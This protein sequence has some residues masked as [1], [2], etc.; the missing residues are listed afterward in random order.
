MAEVQHDHHKRKS[1]E[2]HAVPQRNGKKW[3]ETNSH[4]RQDHG[5]YG[6][7]LSALDGN[8]QSTPGEIPLHLETTDPSTLYSNVHLGDEQV[9]AGEHRNSN[10]A[11]D[12]QELADVG[13]Y[14]P[15]PQTYGPYSAGV[16]KPC[17]DIEPGPSPPPYVVTTSPDG[18]IEYYCMAKECFIDTPPFPTLAEFKQHELRHVPATIMQPQQDPPLVAASPIGSATQAMAVQPHVFATEEQPS[19]ATAL[20]SCNQ[21]SPM[22]PTTSLVNSDDL[23]VLRRVAQFPI[24][25]VIRT[26]SA[27]QVLVYCCMVEGCKWTG[28]FKTEKLVRKHQ[29]CHIQKDELPFLCGENGCIERFLYAAYRLRHQEEIHFGI[30]YRCM[31]CPYRASKYTNVYGKGRHFEKCHPGADKPTIDK[32]RIDMRS[33]TS[34]RA[35][36]DHATSPL[37]HTPRPDSAPRRQTVHSPHAPDAPGRPQMSH[38]RSQHCQGEHSTGRTN[39]NDYVAQRQSYSRHQ[40]ESSPVPAG[41]SSSRR[42]SAATPLSHYSST[43]MSRQGSGAYSS[44]S[45]FMSTP[46]T[47]PTSISSHS[48]GRG[49]YSDAARRAVRSTALLSTPTRASRSI[50][51]ASPASIIQSRGQSSR[52]TYGGGT[53]DIAIRSARS[54]HCFGGPGSRRHF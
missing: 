52:N 39:T 21:T 34:T 22:S 27:V 2:E 20:P 25:P 35:L 7:T 28:T 31:E 36:Q 18:E 1:E 13:Q 23:K 15:L 9:L 10:P 16:T 4:G 53:F 41:P 26:I 14:E 37:P 42:I 40:S 45:S 54:D 46:S 47:A 49:S 3:P 38:A 32:V 51:P 17:V 44:Q 43:A 11:R 48:E 12:A 24:E 50:T 33:S 6:Q 30:Q 29:R 8:L 19:Q 5:A